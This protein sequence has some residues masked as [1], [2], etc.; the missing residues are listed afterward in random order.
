LHLGSVTGSLEAGKRA[1]LILVDISPLHNSPRFR[2]DNNNPYAQ[3]V[4]SGKATDVTDVMVDGKWLMQARKLRTLNENE[5]VTGANEYARKID[6]F[7]MAREQSVFSKL[8]ALGGSAEEESFEV[9]V[10]VKLTDPALVL[11][12][13]KKPAIE[14]CARGTTTNTMHTLPLMIR[15]RVGCATGRMRSLT[16]RNKSPVCAAD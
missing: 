7:L 14:Y 3:M 6:L 4:Y 8:V 9:Q 16:T 13:L 5:L 11:K 1:D 10:K 12:A 2:R 15:H